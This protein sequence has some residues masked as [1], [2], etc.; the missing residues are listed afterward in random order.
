MSNFISFLFP[1]YHISSFLRRQLLLE[2]VLEG[3]GIGG[4]LADTLAQ[5][6]DGHLVLVEVESEEGLVA[7][8]GLLLDVEGRGLGSVELLGD[9]I[10]GVEEL[11]E[12]VGLR[13]E[14]MLV[15]KILFAVQRD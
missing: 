6:L 13:K 12:Q 4:E 2:D 7:D 9:G 1:N 14:E 15:I 11:L 3:D 5:L 10:V 8:V